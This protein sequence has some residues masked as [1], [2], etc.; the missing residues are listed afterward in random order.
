MTNYYGSQVSR[1][2]EEFAK[3][4]GVGA[5]SA[6]RMAFYVLKSPQERAEALSSA[7]LTAR[8]T[9]K[10]CK[11]CQNLTDEEVCFVCAGDNRDPQ[12][13]MVVESPQ[14]MAAYEKTKEYS[15]LYHVLHGAI[16]PMDGIGPSELRI[17]ELLH[18][19]DT[20][21][22]ITEVILATNPN[23][24]GEATAIYLS[25]LLKP[26]GVRTTRIAHGVPVGGDLEHVDSVTLMRALQ[27][28]QEL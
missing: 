27:G 3:L 22:P 26:L 20:D 28:R 5:K 12:T 10:Y 24:E 21:P 6:Q 4:P 7:I 11:Y 15:G 25:K 13:V 1:L 2:I 23:I 14:D 8:S 16:S 9:A 18:R 17:K 19:L